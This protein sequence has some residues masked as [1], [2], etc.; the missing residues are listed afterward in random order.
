MLDQPLPRPCLSAVPLTLVLAVALQVAT[1]WSEVLPFPQ[2]DGSAVPVGVMDWIYREVQTP[3]KYGIVLCGEEGERVDGLKVFRHGDR[4]FMI[5]TTFS[6]KIGYETCL[7]R[8]QHIDE[9][10][11][12][13]SA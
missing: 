11:I 1:P 2:T 10:S 7:A 3:F 12:P 5:H 4:W 8:D 6:E 13:E 9:R